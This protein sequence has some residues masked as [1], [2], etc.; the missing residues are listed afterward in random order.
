MFE[1]NECRIKLSLDSTSTL[2][3]RLVGV[4]LA[5]T[6]IILH[7]NPLISVDEATSAFPH[8]E[9]HDTLGDVR[10]GIALPWTCPPVLRFSAVDTLRND[11][12]HYYNI[13]AARE[14]RMRI[15]AR[16]NDFI[17]FM[18]THRRHLS[19]AAKCK[20]SETNCEGS[21][22]AQAYVRISKRNL[23]GMSSRPSL[24][25]IIVLQLRRHINNLKII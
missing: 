11:M 12:L 25:S 17:I 9:L 7:A 3:A 13:V 10:R 21:N 15:G 19:P 6:I 18:H 4:W 14:T 1:P 16:L 23:S 22:E 24:S 8:S 20:V 2:F 5:I